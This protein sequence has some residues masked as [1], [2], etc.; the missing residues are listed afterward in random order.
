MASSP[1]VACRVLPFAFM[2]LTILLLPACATKGELKRLTQEVQTSAAQ[3]QNLKAETRTVF[4]TTKKQLDEREQKLTQDLKSVQQAVLQLADSVNG[5][6]AKLA[7][8][9]AEDQRLS[10]ETEELRAVVQSTARTLVDFLRT[11]ETQLKEGLRWVQAVLRKLAVE[12][13]SAEAKP[14][15]AKP[16]ASSPQ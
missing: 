16:V 2:W 1:I 4:E 8:S 7:E 10:R 6:T 13:K 15:E 11:E 9:A 3:I 14:L 12:T 5:H